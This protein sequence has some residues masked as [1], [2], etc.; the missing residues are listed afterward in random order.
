ME[1]AEKTTVEEVVETAAD[2]AGDGAAHRALMC[3]FILFLFEF[4]KT[5]MFL[6]FRNR[7]PFRFLARMP[8]T[9]LL[10]II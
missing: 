5:Y 9:Y 3:V 7:T 2:G 1:E 10:F 6:S 8:V 4:V